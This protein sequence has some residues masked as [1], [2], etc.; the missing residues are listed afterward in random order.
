MFVPLSGK[1]VWSAWRSKKKRYSSLHGHGE[2][3]KPVIQT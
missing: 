1:S 3:D 2:P